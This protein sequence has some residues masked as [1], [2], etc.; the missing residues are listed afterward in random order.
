MLKK[1]M[2]NPLLINETQCL[3]V[4]SSSTSSQT[5][6]TTNNKLIKSFK[7]FK[8]EE[9]QLNEIRKYLNDNV[10]QE[11]EEDNNERLKVL[12][13]EFLVK[14]KLILN[15]EYK[16]KQLVD[17]LLSDNFK[18]PNEIVH[19]IMT[20]ISNNDELIERFSVF[21]VEENIYKY[22][23]FIHMNF[24]ERLT[25]LIRLLDVFMS[26][27]AAFKRL[28]QLIITNCSK[29]LNFNN[30]SNYVLKECQKNQ[31]EQIV[32]DIKAKIKTLTKNN[33]LICYHLDNL[34]NQTNQFNPQFEKI[35]LINTQN[36]LLNKN[37]SFERIDL[38]NDNSILNDY[39][40]KK[41]SCLCHTNDN[42]MINHCFNCSIKIIKGKLY[43]KSEGKKAIPLKYK[44]LD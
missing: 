19:E 42:S 28:L 21:L 14:C 1:I 7:R 43:L 23:L 17:T 39:G 40:T 38:S 15:N 8:K 22:D 33:R 16:Y 41:C 30:N 3:D 5:S 24:H 11:D 12:A 6:T 4:E 34:F 9:E 18:T 35:N 25:Q 31:Q 32:N 2:I 26:N 44:I 10:E 27:K 29:N 13:K 20:L 37:M 36:D